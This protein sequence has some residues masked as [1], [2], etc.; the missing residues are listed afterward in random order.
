MG[1][2]RVGAGSKH[3]RGRGTAA[4]GAAAAPLAAERPP[5]KALIRQRGWHDLL[6]G[7]AL[8]ALTAAAYAPAMQAG[9]IWDDG[10]LIFNNRLIR[11]GDGL[12]RFWLTTQPT[13]YFPLTWTTL[14]IEWRLWGS[15]PTGY[16]VVNLVLHALS[17]VVI[18][19][20]LRRLSL[21][22]AWVA[23]AV[24]AVHP[25]T[26]ASVA[27][28]SE[29]KNTLSLLLFSLSLL[30]YLRFD[31]S[32]RRRAYAASLGLFL[33]ALLA[34]TSVVMMPLVLLGLAWWR[35]GVVAGRD[36]LRVSPFL[37][38]SAVL[39]LVTVYFQSHNV[40]ST[41]EV[42]PE[43]F[44]SR[45]AATGWCVGFYLYKCLAPV[46]LSMIYPR[47]QVDPASLAAWL[48]LLALLALAVAAVCRRRTWGRPVLAGLGYS[49][50]MLLPVL[51][52]AQMY[53]QRYSLVADHFQY[54]A[55]IGPI[56]LAVGVAGR[57]RTPAARRAAIGAAALVLAVLSILT[58]RRCHVYD[59]QQ[60]LWSD[61]LAKNP[62]AWVGH[63]NLAG[64][65]RAQGRFGDALAHYRRALEITPD[66]DDAL[67]N[68]GVILHAQGDADGA[69]DHYRRAL[70]IQAD[71]AQAHN[72]LGV[73]LQSQGELISAIDHFRRALQAEPAYAEAHYN[74]GS[75]LAGQ[76]D[77]EQAIRHYRLAL[78]FRPDWAAPMAGLAWTLA[79]RPDAAGTLGGGAVALA[80]RACQLT[81][82]QNA[83]A[84]DALAAAYAAA[85][86][87][88]QAAA[89]AQRAIAAAHA[90]NAPDLADRIGGRLALYRQAKAYQEP[91][92]APLEPPP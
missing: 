58:W 37:V 5:A 27:W 35:R 92:P 10:D 18:W 53:F 30:A 29:R 32:G 34:K 3:R 77:A 78:E 42:R 13:D 71:H 64:V 38:L 66:Y 87:F 68:I 82:F 22:A 40:I 79:T 54:A 80:E 2:Q 47:W 12:Y 55:L 86:R 14:W 73:L 84:L 48:P 52:L 26:V 8:L 24:F 46:A 70:A 6:A 90:A 7:A 56:A 76:G 41:V 89:T 15:D 21:P 59:N 61:T 51:G 85:G 17:A 62:D 83:A 28:I 63:N 1:S 50:L 36:L 23:A 75:A 72:N 31:E 4:S 9:L 65:Y 49:V 45:L 74:L 19:R 67:Y 11:A 25:V 88:D 91:P 39:G 57:P 81:G 16:H 44:L 69:I 33:L 60:S 20:V 43:G